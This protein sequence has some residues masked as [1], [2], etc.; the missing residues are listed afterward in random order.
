MVLTESIL[1]LQIEW[2]ETAVGGRKRTWR[3]REG[4][5]EIVDSPRRR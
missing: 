4:E 5:I 3:C 1:L 2:N